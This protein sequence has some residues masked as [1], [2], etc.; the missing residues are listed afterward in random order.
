MP[1]PPSARR[2]KY[3]VS[4]ADGQDVGNALVGGQGIDRRRA[5]SVT[6][7]PAGMG[8]SRSTSHVTY[9]A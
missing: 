1:G 3:P 2:D 8:A 7:S 5:A 9:C 4:G 6:R